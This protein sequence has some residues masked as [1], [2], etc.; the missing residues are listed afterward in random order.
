MRLLPGN[1]IWGLTPGFAATFSTGFSF[2]KIFRERLFSGIADYRRDVYWPVCEEPSNVALIGLSFAI[3][4]TAQPIKKLV[5]HADLIRLFF[6]VSRLSIRS[7]AGVKPKGSIGGL[8]MMAP[9]PPN[10]KIGQEEQEMSGFRHP[11]P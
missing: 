11:K 3:S 7:S 1:Q 6:R 5:L 2:Q 10:H 4:S 9:S 8:W